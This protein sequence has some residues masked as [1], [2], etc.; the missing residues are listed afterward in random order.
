[1]RRASNTKVIILSD[2]HGFIDPRILE[3][4]CGCQLAVHAGDVMG[5]EIL[6]ALGRVVGRVAAVS[7]NND[8]PGKWVAREHPV[9]AS[10]PTEATLELPGGIL[11]V[12]H[13]HRIWDYRDRHG[14]LRRRYPDARAVVYGHSHQLVCDQDEI[15]WVLNPGAAGRIRTGSGPSCILLHAG[16]DSWRLEP[17]RF[18]PLAR[19]YTRLAG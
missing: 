15:P 6:E 10:L 12:T 16:R 7:G 11:A 18:P 2:T 3:L 13:G 4:A 19:K 17:R 14:R 5:A 9:L 8:V 1:M